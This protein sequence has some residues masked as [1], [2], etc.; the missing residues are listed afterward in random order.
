MEKSPYKKLDAI[1]INSGAVIDLLN[2]SFETVLANIIDPNTKADAV[3]KV[4]LTISIK[5]NE[6]LTQAATEIEV[7]E[8]LAPVKG[9]AGNI[10]LF[11]KNGK[12]HGVVDA[13]DEMPMFPEDERNPNV[14][15]FDELRQKANGG[16]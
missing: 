4:T 12:L 11:E 5:P 2:N 15:N 14:T 9:S 1:S 16:E 3:R 7:K 13:L 10:K 6:E 8:T